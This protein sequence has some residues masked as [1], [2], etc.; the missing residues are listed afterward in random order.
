MTNLGVYLITQTLFYPN[1]LLYDTMVVLKL[2]DINFFPRITFF[3][4]DWL[5]TKLLI[6]N[7]H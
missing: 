5:M 6:D 7:V 2:I 3:F 4:L 1:S